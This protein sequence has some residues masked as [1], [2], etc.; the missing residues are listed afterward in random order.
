MIDVEPLIASELAQM[1]P[2]PDGGR[3]DWSDVLQRAGFG[4]SRWPWR[5]VL[6]AA[7]A[8]GALIGVGVALAASFGAFHGIK[9]AQHP[10]TRRDRLDRAD[11]PPDCSS[12]SPAATTSPFCHMILSS[13]RLLRTVPGGGKLWVVTD[14]HGDLCVVLQ[15]GGA[16]C[17]SGL[18]H[19]QPTTITSFKRGPQ[20]PAISWGV[21]LNDV[22]A[23]SFPVYGREVTIPVKH[24]VWV[25]KGN[26]Y[27]LIHSATIHFKDGSA[28]RPQSD[29][30][31]FHPAKSP[32]RKP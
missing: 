27:G 23:I 16:S 4:N 10:Q 2:L 30:P 14:T 9:A 17:G 1:L 8:L 26:Y 6:I 13:S 12:G 28:E 20:T 3:A 32:L 5:R 22:K 7:V 18:T 15:R 29:I 19:R 31:P 21:T 11:F 24:N 25:W